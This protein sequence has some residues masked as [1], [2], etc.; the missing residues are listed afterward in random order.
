M[1][2]LI[3]EKDG[4]FTLPLVLGHGLDHEKMFGD[5]AHNDEHATYHIAFIEDTWSFPHPDEDHEWSGEARD[6]GW[7]KYYGGPRE[8][9]VKCGAIRN[10]DVD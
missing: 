5:I 3:K 6:E 10:M 2:A 9:C 1:W 4:K 7:P 8:E